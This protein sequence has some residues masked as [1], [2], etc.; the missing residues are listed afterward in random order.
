MHISAVELVEGISRELAATADEIRSHRFLDLLGRRA[1]PDDRLRALAAEEHTIVHSD[2]RS[3]AQLAARFPD[4]P[5]GEFFLALAEGEGIALRKL[6]GLAEWLDLTGDD[7]HT[8]EPLPGAQAYP[9]FVAWL[10]LNG[11]RLDVVLALLANFAAWGDNCGKAAAALREAYGASDVAVA[12]FDFFTQAPP[13]FEN[14][15]LAVIEEAIADGDS[16]TLARRATRLLQAYELSF[17]D[18][19][20]EGL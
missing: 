8:Y 3:F 9:A 16:P 17:W 5:S 7:L 2:R 15:A 1:I 4:G 19:L 11:S 20:T 14:T 10:A 18:T 12:F 6:R 13:D